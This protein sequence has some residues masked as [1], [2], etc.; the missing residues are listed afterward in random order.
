MLNSNHFSF[1]F[2]YQTKPMKKKIYLILFLV[3]VV[4]VSSCTTSRGTAGGGCSMN[5][6]FVGYN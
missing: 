5:R 6:N 2:D 3:V 4:F 1:I